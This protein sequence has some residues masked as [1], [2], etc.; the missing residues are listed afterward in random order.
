M[1]V[2]GSPQPQTLAHT[3]PSAAQVR[4]R[5]GGRMATTRAHEARVS[6]S[7]GSHRVLA[8]Q[9]ARE[10]AD[11]AV[12]MLVFAFPLSAESVDPRGAARH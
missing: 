3:Q 12:R 9:W 6:S 1:S 11:A 5:H 10:T 8:R 7:S 4:T 2:R